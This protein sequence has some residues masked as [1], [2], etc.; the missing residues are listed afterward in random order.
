MAPVDNPVHLVWLVEGVLSSTD[1]ECRPTGRDETTLER[2]EL[3]MSLL[4]QEFDRIDTSRGSSIDHR[5]VLKLKLE[6]SITRS[7]VKDMM[8]SR[9]MQLLQ[10]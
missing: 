10:K 3:L 9:T 7:E 8:K 5:V 4:E 1:E 6:G 2:R